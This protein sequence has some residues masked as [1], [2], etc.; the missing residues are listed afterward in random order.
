MDNIRAKLR[1]KL[2]MH[3]KDANIDEHEDIDEETTGHLHKQ[4]EDAEESNHP[5]GR[6]GSFLN[7]LISHGNKKTED[8]LAAEIAAGQKTTT[9][10]TAT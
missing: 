7:R 1:R 6:P 5:Q 8:Q 4:I 9:T 10:T 3:D 2:S